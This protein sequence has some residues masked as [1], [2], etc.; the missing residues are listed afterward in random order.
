VHVSGVLQKGR[1]RFFVQA[2][3]DTHPAI[4]PSFTQQSYDIF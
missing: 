1:G 4:V 3:V 2:Q